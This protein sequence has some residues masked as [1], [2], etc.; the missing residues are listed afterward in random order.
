MRRQWSA[1][2][3][4][5]PLACRPR[6]GSED[7][8]LVALY[9]HAPPAHAPP[10]TVRIKVIGGSE[11]EVGTAAAS[12]VWGPQLRTERHAPGLRDWSSEQR[13]REVAGVPPAPRLPLTPFCSADPAHA[14]PVEKLPLPLAMR[15]VWAA[16]RPL[17]YAAGS[18]V[19]QKFMENPSAM[20]EALSTMR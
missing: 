15:R 11:R 7:C 5:Q 19:H 10:L 16:A 2:S 18:S 20:L 6:R 17:T 14:F 13:S 4:S 3:A 1:W 8:R 9:R 12:L